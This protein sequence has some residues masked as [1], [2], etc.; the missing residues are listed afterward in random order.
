V[1]AHYRRWC[2]ETTD[3]EKIRH[4][5]AVADRLAAAG[6]PYEQL[7][8]CARLLDG[9]YGAATRTFSASPFWALY[10]HFS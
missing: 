8:R 2:R 3:A 10:T 6:L 1:G 7:R 4:L 5:Y 9:R